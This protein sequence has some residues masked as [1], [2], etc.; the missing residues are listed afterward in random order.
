MA[1]ARDKKMG[2]GRQAKNLKFG[3]ESVRFDDFFVIFVPWWLN[4]YADSVRDREVI[5]RSH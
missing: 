3:S 5:H 1:L 2:K 4:S